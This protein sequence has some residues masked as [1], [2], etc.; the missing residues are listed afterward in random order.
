VKIASEPHDETIPAPV[1]I[2]R[3]AGRELH[4]HGIDYMVI[5]D[6]DWGS[7]DVRED[8]AS[9]GFKEIAKG[10]GARIFRTVEP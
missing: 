9:W 2:R 8:P 6:T 10:Y 1:D 7:E 3:W 4:L 5:R